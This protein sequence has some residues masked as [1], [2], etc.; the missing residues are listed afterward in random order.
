MRGLETG[1]QAPDFL[2]KDLDGR[3]Y[4]LAAEQ[5]G[6]RLLLFFKTECPTTPLLI[7]YV[8]RVHEIYG[9]SLA[10][11][12]WGISQ[13][14]PSA[15][16]AFVAQHHITF[17]ILLD[18]DWQASITYDLVIVPVLFLVDEQ[19]VIRATHAGLNKAALNNLAADIAE[20][21]GRAAVTVAPPDDGRPIFRPG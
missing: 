2:L 6:W 16:A 17:P 12:V 7:P 3:T 5:Q 18:E 13:D 10:F 14:P 8:K 9:G 11:Q 15:T 19:G 20:H 4:S 1:Q 21:L